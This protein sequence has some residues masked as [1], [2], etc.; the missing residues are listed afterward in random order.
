MIEKISKEEW[1]K[2]IQFVDKCIKDR[3]IYHKPEVILTCDYIIIGVL[4]FS[5]LTGRIALSMNFAEDINSSMTVEFPYTYTVEEMIEFSKS[6]KVTGHSGSLNGLG[7]KSDE[8][9]DWHKVKSTSEKK[10]RPDPTD[11]DD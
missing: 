9:L 8:Y 3:G 11:G 1:Y 2:F 6:V 10:V 4:N 7:N 5:R